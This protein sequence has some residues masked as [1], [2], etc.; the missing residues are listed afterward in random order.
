MSHSGWVLL[1]IWTRM[2]Q[3]FSL[4]THSLL[5]SQRSKQIKIRGWLHSKLQKLEEP[6]CPSLG[7]QIN[8][9]HIQTMRDYL[10]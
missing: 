9:L 2:G 5:W 6:K 4:G 3:N 10:H 7:E 8:K 1:G